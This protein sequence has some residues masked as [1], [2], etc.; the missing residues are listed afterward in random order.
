MRRSLRAAGS[1]NWARRSAP[2]GSPRVSEQL[3]R[4]PGLVAL[5]NHGKPFGLWYLQ[6]ARIGRQ[7]SPRFAFM[8]RPSTPQDASGDG[9]KTW[10]A[11]RYGVRLIQRIGLALAFAIFVCCSLRFPARCRYRS[12]CLGF[13][14]STRSVSASV[15]SGMPGAGVA[16]GTN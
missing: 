1:R 14:A 11:W 4:R 2:G 9:G 5:W 12:S 10:L 16:H 3:H 13:D 8:R 6:V 7:H 15:D